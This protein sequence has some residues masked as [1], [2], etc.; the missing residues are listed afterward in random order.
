MVNMAGLTL[1]VLLV[2]PGNAHAAEAVAQS[3]LIN[4]SEYA[5]RLEGFWLGASIGNWTGRITEMD[6]I[7]GDGPHGIFY[8]MDDWGKPD[9]PNIWDGGKP[10]DISDVIDFV[11]LKPGQVW[12]ADDDTDIEYIY[13]EH[14]YANNSTELSG[15]DVRT[16]WMNHIYD[17]NFPT[18]FGKDGKVFQNYLWVSNQRA[19]ELMIEGVVPP[20]TG[21][22]DLNP[23]WEMIDAQLTTEI[24][25]LFSPG[26]PGFALR[27]AEMP[28]R[29][30]AR[31]EAE[32]AAKFYVVMHSLAAGETWTASE[33]REKLFHIAGRARKHLPGNSY[34]AS[35][36]DFVKRSYE[37]GMPWETARDQLYKRYQ[38]DEADGYDM[39]SRKLYCNGCF[40]A[41]I[42]F[43]A[44][45]ISLFYGEGDFKKTVKI[46]TLAG[47]DSDNPAAT[48]GGL[49][50]FILGRS[51]LEGLFGM[52][53]SDE[54]HIHRTRKG[55]PNDGYDNFRNMAEKGIS[56][57]DNM[58]SQRLGGSINP[59]RNTWSLERDID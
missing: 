18:P 28:I 1:F 6:K 4:R 44:S 47:W 5:D 53:L 37:N 13:Q 23:H 36:Y 12:G 45:M 10:S 11:L 17:E 48:W 35:M 15:S 27:L 55:F 58:V 26:N 20:E 24:F 39:T 41:G 19:H 30:T 51:G 29:T 52:K 2:V 7:G 56:V 25:G 49:L 34:M 54:Y 32:H 42:N 33:T 31:G 8:T 22:A 21:R 43:G 9:L 57:V 46:A 59:D 38:V 40:A 16:A 3:L 14:L 50:G